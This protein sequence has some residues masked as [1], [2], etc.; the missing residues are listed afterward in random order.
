ML[1]TSTLAFAQ[2]GSTITQGAKA[3]GEKAKQ[4]ADEARASV[5]SQP[6]KTVYKAKAQVHKAKAEHHAKAASDAAKEI[7]K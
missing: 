5:S 2:V 4:Y 7:P 3:T 1:G 6:D